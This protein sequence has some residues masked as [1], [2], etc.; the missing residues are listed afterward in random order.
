MA[1]EATAADA[2]ADTEADK[3]DATEIDLEQY[4]ADHPLVTAFNAQKAKLADTH[5][6]YADYDALK[7]KAEKFDQAEQAAKSDAEK[8]AEALANL[9][10]ENESLK[11]AALRAEVA[12]TKGVD[13][14]LLTG[15]TKEELEAAADKLL[16]WK[17]G[18]A[19]Q[20]PG[21]KRTAGPVS[22]VQ[23]PEETRED[24]KKRL[25]E[26]YKR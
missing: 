15:S 7:A 9:Q 16:A 23:S 3:G 5:K 22:Q 14:D 1:N 21:N 25:A 26:A 11:V 10:R 13:P 17:G 12:A 19:P 20:L 24:R 4:P 6:R 18:T 2:G 8:Q